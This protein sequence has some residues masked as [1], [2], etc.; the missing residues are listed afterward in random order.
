MAPPSEFSSTIFAERFMIMAIFDGDYELGQ[1]AMKTAQKFAIN[2][3]S[4]KQNLEK[5][6]N[7]LELSHLVVTVECIH[8]RKLSLFLPLQHHLL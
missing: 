5:Y 1:I 3:I 2:C 7:K 6:W 8:D 4:S